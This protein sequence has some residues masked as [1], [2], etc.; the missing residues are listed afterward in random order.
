MLG[1]RWVMKSGLI[2]GV[3]LLLAG[4]LAGCAAGGAGGVDVARTHLGEPIARAQ[5]A[6]EPS[7]AADANNPEFS[8][9]AAAVERELARN[10]YSVVRGLATS[11]QVARIGVR[12]G[13]HGALTTGWAGVQPRRGDAAT[14]ATLLDV[15]IQRRSDGTVFWQGR[16]VAEASA[17]GDR[18]AMVQRLAT[19]LFAGFP[20]ESG[21][22]IRVR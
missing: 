19:A 6:I 21:R 15:R 16:A 22:T 14:T 3:T 10:G 9:Y 17:A 2:G 13:T 20:G 1:A 5:I 4:L 11:E 12:Q 18:M 8:A 7:N